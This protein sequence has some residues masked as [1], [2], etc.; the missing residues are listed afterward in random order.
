MRGAP[1]AYPAAHV[2]RHRGRR[3]PQSRSPST[4]TRSSSVGTIATRQRRITDILNHSRRAVPRP[5]GR[6]VEEFGTRGETI[7]G[8]VRPD[9]PRLRPVRRRRRRRSRRRPSCGRPRSRGGA[10]SRSRRS[11]SPARSTCCPEHDL[12]E[13]L[14]ELHRPLPA[15][16]RGDVLVGHLGEARQTGRD[17]G[18]QPRRAQILAPHT[19]STRGRTPWRQRGRTGSAPPGRSTGPPP[20]SPRPTEPT[21][22]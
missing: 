10:R 5:R 2:R 3:R 11:R 9:Q 19:R 21:G 15:G 20:T 13:A 4:P 1:A 14:S 12:R 22:W 17:R 8:R 16:D 7:Q 6:D 18:G